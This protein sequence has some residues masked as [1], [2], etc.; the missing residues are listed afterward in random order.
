ARLTGCAG[1]LTLYDADTPAFRGRYERLPVDTR[2]NCRVADNEYIEHVTRAHGAQRD[3]RGHHRATTA[4]RDN[5]AVVSERSARAHHPRRD[6]TAR[7]PPGRPCLRAQGIRDTRRH[8]CG[9]RA[10]VLDL[11]GSIGDH[12]RPAYRISL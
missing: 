5:A 8:R 3:A 12:T 4:G 10:L 7:R 9:P 11:G 1:V 2:R 6:R